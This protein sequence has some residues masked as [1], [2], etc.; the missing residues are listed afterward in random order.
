MKVY[1]V[2]P[3]IDGSSLKGVLTDDLSNALEM[4]RD[5][6]VDEEENRVTVRVVN[7]SKKAYEDVPEI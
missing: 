2:S 7:M 4:V 3:P 5:L 1:Q 6:I